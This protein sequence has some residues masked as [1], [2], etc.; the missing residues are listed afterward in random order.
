VDEVK[1]V[2]NLPL[3]LI[4]DEDETFQARLDYDEEEIKA[5]A[6][7]IRRY[8]Q[9]NPIGVQPKGERFQIIYGFQ[10]VKALK[11][12]GAQTVKANVYHGLSVE[13]AYAISVSDN[14]MLMDLTDL[15]RALKAQKMRRMGFSIEEL[16]ALFNLKKSTIYNLLKVAESDD[17]IQTCLHKKLITLNHAVELMRIKDFSKRLETLKMV[18]AWR[19]SVRDLKRWIK[20]KISPVMYFPTTGWWIKLC[21]KTLRIAPQRECQKCEYHR[22]IHIVEG[23]PKIAC[24]FPS[25]DLAPLF[26]NDEKR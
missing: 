13:E 19:W 23:R 18:I 8:G 12:L 14:E 6:E 20:N 2:E 16:S 3:D 9:R 7:D 24:A 21:P 5:L 25:D 22:G 17:A 15:E 10:R 11:Y 26:P 4:D 1:Y